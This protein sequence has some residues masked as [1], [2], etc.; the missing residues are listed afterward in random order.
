MLVKF[1]ENVVFVKKFLNISILFKN[2]WRFRFRS[3][4]LEFSIYLQTNLI[5]AKIFKLS[6][7][8]KNCRKLS[9]FLSKFSKIL[10]LVKN[11]K[12]LA[13][14]KKFRKCW[15]WSKFRKILMSV[16]ILWKSWHLSKFSKNLDFSQDFRKSRFLSKF[17]KL[18]QI[19][20]KFLM[21][22]N[23]VKIFDNLDFVQN[24]R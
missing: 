2:F 9:R 18:C 17:R 12:I 24:F 13:S 1:F 10:I 6:N 22:L 4:F 8:V 15:F 5:L 23:F 19:L 14:G 21:I 3:K 20:S 7:F 16:K 11:H